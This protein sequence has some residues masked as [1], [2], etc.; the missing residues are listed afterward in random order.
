[1]NPVLMIF[2][3]VSLM[4]FGIIAI[5]RW[6]DHAFWIIIILLFDPSGH[7]TVYFGKDALG[8]FHYQDFLFV[9]AFVPL[10]SSKVEVKHLLHFRPFLIVLGVQLLFLLYHVFVFGYWQP[11]KGW[12]YLVRYVLVRE[13]MS[14]FGFLLIIPSFVMA[15]RNL[16][17]LVDVLGWSSLVVFILF[18]LTVFTDFEFVPVWQAERY[19]GTGIMRYFMYSAGLTDMLLPLTFFVLSRKINYR[20][21]QLLYTATVLFVIAVMLSL[22]KS[23]YINLA[24]LV[25]GSLFLYYRYYRASLTGLLGMLLGPGLALLVLMYAMFPEYPGLVWR[26]VEDLW[27]FISGDAYTSGVVEGR[28]LNQWPA[29]LAIIE[30]HPWFGTG[31]DFAGHF[32]LRFDP[33]DYE[34]TDLPITG[35]LAMYGFVGLAI[36]SLLYVQLWRYLVQGY[37]TMKRSVLHV[38]EVDM[39]FFFVVF[40]WMIKTFV[41]KPNYLFNE[42]TTGT[43]LINLY[44]GILIALLYRNIKT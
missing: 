38:N 21:R 26:Q 2:L 7:L 42:L 35:H 15:R 8:G 29:H 28:L 9:L 11:G 36:Y 30:Q 34:V 14:V 6:P 24:G 13:R 27:L 1:M 19:R 16:S 31:A 4:A 3:L 10:I 41:F 40:A 22:T 12:D 32:S 25:V 20:Y 33:S 17:I 39:A 5:R 43:L 37:K 23:N 44:A 18:F